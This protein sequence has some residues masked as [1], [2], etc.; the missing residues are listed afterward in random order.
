MVGKMGILAPL[1]DEISSNPTART[2][3]YMVN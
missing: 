1:W 2:G 3:C